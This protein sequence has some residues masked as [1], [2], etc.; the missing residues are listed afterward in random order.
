MLFYPELLSMGMPGAIFTNSWFTKNCRV[1]QSGGLR[2]FNRDR[3]VLRE[4][5]EDYCWSH[6][7]ERMTRP[8]Y[9]ADGRPYFIKDMLI[10]KETLH[11]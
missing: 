6:Y 11:K 10:L 8:L 9:I 4:D 2:R 3:Y 1:K 5:V 7:Q